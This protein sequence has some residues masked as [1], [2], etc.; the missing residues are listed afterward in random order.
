MKLDLSFDYLTIKDYEHWTLQ[1]ACNQSYLGRC[2]IWCK[3]ENAEDL[4]DM[5][6]DESAELVEI[7]NELK[8]AEITAFNTDWFNYSFL[9]NGTRHLHCHFIPRYETKREFSGITFEDKFWGSNFKTD[10]DF[11]TTDEIREKVKLELKKHI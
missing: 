3:R 1:V 6:P 4:S 5:T 9:G 10:P 2:I 7:L 11:V 8:K